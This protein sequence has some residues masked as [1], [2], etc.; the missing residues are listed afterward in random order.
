MRMFPFVV[1]I[2]SIYLIQSPSK[3]LRNLYHN[4]LYMTFVFSYVK[5][6]VHIEFDA[7]VM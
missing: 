5:F 6:N 1:P 4:T 3:I 7:F 2:Y